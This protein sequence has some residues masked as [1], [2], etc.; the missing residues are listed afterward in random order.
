MEGGAE[1][2]CA[3]RKKSIR[4]WNCR[5]GRS[6]DPEERKEE[7]NEVTFKGNYPIYLNYPTTS[8]NK[9][10]WGYGK[11][12]HRLIYE[13]INRGRNSYERLLHRFLSYKDKYLALNRDEDGQMIW[14]PHL[15]NP[16]LPGLDSLSLYCMFGINKPTKYIEIG[17]GNSTK[18]AKKSTLDNDLK[19]KIISIDPEP[20]AE[21]DGM[22]DELLRKPVEEV[23]CSFFDQLD[24]NDILFI[25]SSHRCFMNSDVTVIFLDILPRLKSGVLVEIH[26]IFLPNDYPPSWTERYYSEQY[27]LAALLLAEGKK[28]V[29]LLPNAFISHDP[30]LHKIVTPIFSAPEMNEV[31]SGGGSFWLMIK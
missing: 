10:R 31:R 29:I 6:F 17:S 30:E 2:R 8:V 13:I 3:I 14:E 1:A 5:L 4:S 23:D 25:D 22:C 19:T 20:R 24:A 27:L 16:W 28:F 18:F 26:D 12:H 21:I 9:P 15:T 11:P 7:K